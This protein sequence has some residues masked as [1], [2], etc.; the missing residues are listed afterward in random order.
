MFIGD[1][2][3]GDGC[4]E[5]RWVAG[6]LI[7]SRDVDGYPLAQRFVAFLQVW[8]RRLP[9]RGFC[10]GGCF[11]WEW[12]LVWVALLPGGPAWMLVFLPGVSQERVSF[13]GLGK[14]I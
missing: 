5:T 10:L 6:A 4:Q 3:Q 8:E 2:A 7:G 11:A 14:L 12:F 1:L 9:R 13:C